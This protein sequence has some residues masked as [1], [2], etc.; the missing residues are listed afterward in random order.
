MRD[1]LRHSASI[2]SLSGI[3]LF[4]SIIFDEEIRTR[5]AIS[6]LCSY[7]SSSELNYLAALYMF[8]DLGL[9]AF[10]NNSL[11]V[12]EQGVT[13]KAED[14]ATRLFY[15]GKLAIEHVIDDGLLNCKDIRFSVEKDSIEL[16]VNAF[17]L[18]AA[19]YRNF[20]ITVNALYIGN[21]KLYVSSK[22]EKCFEKVCSRNAKK[23]TQ[24]DLLK[25]LDQQQ[26][27]GEKAEL[28][29]VEY[30]NSRLLQFGKQ[31]KRISQIDVAAGYDILS[32]EDEKSDNYDLYIEV[33][34]Y[35]GKPHFYWSDNERN[36]SM[37]LKDKYY[38]ILVDIDRMSDEGYA[39][40]IV[41]NPYDNLSKDEWLM[42]PQTYFVCKI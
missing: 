13:L 27:D 41:K 40:T 42:K 2:G 25:K 7:V 32:F 38:L 23:I 30:E 14:T 16:P 34:A 26:I 9:I 11:S 12:T 6:S 20:L 39:P 37:A 28:Y 36:T 4:T 15:M 31:A 24:E 33:K 17:S 29:V 10:D 3:Q 22:Y 8:D 1:E 18:S 21:G 19:V 5:K 35:H